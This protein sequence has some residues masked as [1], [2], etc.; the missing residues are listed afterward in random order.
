MKNL[1][2]IIAFAALLFAA[3]LKAQFAQDP[4]LVKPQQPYHAPAELAAKPVPAPVKQ[5][6]A[7]SQ[8]RASSAAS[9]AAARKA[10]QNEAPKTPPATNGHVAAHPQSHQAALKAQGAK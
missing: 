10:G 1:K 4:T 5:R 2:L 8:Q 3:G 7:E 9:A 6:G